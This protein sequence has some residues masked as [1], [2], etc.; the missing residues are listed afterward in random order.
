[1]KKR[2]LSK[3]VLQII[4]VV[5]MFSDHAW[6]VG[7]L[8]QISNPWMYTIMQV[9]GSMTIVIMA[10][11]IAEGFHKTNNLGRYILRMAVFAAISQIPYYFAVNGVGLKGSV[12]GLIYSVFTYRNTIFTLFV[13]LCLLTVLKSSYRLI[14]KLVAIVAALWLVKNSD[15]SY[16]AILWI[17]GFGL[18]YGDKRKQ[19]LWAAFVVF[20][21]LILEAI[22]PVQSL[23]DNNML[24]LIV[25][26]N[27]LSIFGGFLTIPL[28]AIYNG[29]RGNLPKWTFYVI[30][31]IHFVVIILLNILL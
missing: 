16:Y 29:E 26:C 17:V 2:G 12:T 20:V 21:R 23:I 10:Y 27:W 14:V 7:R 18:F 22:S 8:W 4:A 15:W 9:I 25:L 19:M 5:A 11:F 30:Y 31:P 1:M 3:A 6:L 13:G 24:R 28:L